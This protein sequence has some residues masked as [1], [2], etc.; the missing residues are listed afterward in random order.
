MK[1]LGSQLAIFYLQY[2]FDLNGK[3]VGPNY[4]CSIIEGTTFDVSGLYEVTSVVQPSLLSVDG[5]LTLKL[6]HLHR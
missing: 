6:S 4:L 5:I 1:T 3:K 2:D